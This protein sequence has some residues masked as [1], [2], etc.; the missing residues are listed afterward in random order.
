MEPLVTILL[1][2][3][4]HEQFLEEALQSL[5]EQSFSNWEAWVLDD[6]STDNSKSI[7]DGFKKIDRRI[8]P[9]YSRNNLGKAKQ[10]NNVLGNVKSKYI[11]F[12]DSD[13]YWNKN[14]LEIQVNTLEQ[15]KSIDIVYTDGII[16][17]SRINNLD[18]T[19]K[20]WNSKIEGKLFSEEHRQPTQ[21]DG[22]VFNELL[23]GNFIFYSSVLF[24]TSSIN[25]IRFSETINR[26]MDWLFFTELSRNSNFKYLSQP[27]AYYRV[28][29]D[30]LQNRV[31][32]SSKKFEALKFILQKYG[33]KIPSEYKARHYY[34]MALHELKLKNFKDARLFA[35]K[36]S[37]LKLSFKTYIIWFLSFVNVGILKY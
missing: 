36:S 20:A 9:I 1:S 26:S 6:A 19:K 29:G 10:L 23:R 24:R 14:K 34:I 7:I 16:V 37:K 27:L 5:I 15:N 33:A 21:R 35:A 18:K 28:H 12:L 11:A 4:N 25:N 3:F 8:V 31:K 2:S 13:D 32:Q 17:D 22:D 30:N